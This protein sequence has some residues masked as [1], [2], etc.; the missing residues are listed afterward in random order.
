MP[1][2]TN[3]KPR[4]PKPAPVP[5]ADELE[6]WDAFVMAA[7]SAML[8]GREPPNKGELERIAEAADLFAELVLVRRRRRFVGKVN[9]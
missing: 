5:P 2:A 1:A 7:G 6:A 3:G 9:D 8:A 4:T